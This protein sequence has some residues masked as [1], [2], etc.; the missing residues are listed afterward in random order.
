MDDVCQCGK[1]ED[2]LCAIEQ[3]LNRREVGEVRRDDLS[4]LLSL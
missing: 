2:A 4:S 3:A 1:M